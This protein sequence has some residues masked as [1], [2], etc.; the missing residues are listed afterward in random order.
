MNTDIILQKTNSINYAVAR[1]RYYIEHNEKEVVKLCLNDIE[2]ATKKIEKEVEEINDFL[3]N[4]D[5]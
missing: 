2:N 4:L 1:I 3:F 5:K